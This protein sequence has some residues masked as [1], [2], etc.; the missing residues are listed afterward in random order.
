MKEP[1]REQG[2]ELEWNISDH[3]VCVVRCVS[4]TSSCSSDPQR[5]QGH[6]S[7]SPSFAFE[8]SERERFF[9]SGNQVELLELVECCVSRLEI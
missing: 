5:D 4:R 7:N 9:E 6:H 1:Q 3:E 2:R 8:G